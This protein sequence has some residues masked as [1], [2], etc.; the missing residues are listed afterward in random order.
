MFIVYQNGRVLISEVV[1]G[2]H[3]STG[4]CIRVPRNT[5]S[6]RSIVCLPAAAAAVADSL[7]TASVTLYLYQQ[8][9]RR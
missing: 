4:M 1:Y 2:A 6:H 7:S 3:K 8:L 5:L 9:C